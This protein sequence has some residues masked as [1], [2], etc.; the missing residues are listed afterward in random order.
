MKLWKI[1]AVSALVV[2]SSAMADSGDRHTTGPSVT[3]PAVPQYTDASAE[4]RI[5]QSGYSN[6]AD[7]NQSSAYK[8]LTDVEQ[9]GDR[10]YSYT[11]QLGDNSRIVVDQFGNDNGSSVAQSANKAQVFVSQNGNGNRSFAS[12]TYDGGLITVQQFGTANVAY[13]NQ[14]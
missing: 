5:Y 1:L 10:N 2:S 3:P 14:H 6:V 11:N 9:R 13:T 8:S 12:Q 7:A 4:I